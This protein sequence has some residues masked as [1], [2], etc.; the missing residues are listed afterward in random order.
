MGASC[1]NSCSCAIDLQAWISW[2]VA[3]ARCSGLASTVRPRK[4]SHTPCRPSCPI[5]RASPR[6]L[7]GCS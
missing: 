5:T 3:A 2:P 6:Q 1:T 7:S 4:A